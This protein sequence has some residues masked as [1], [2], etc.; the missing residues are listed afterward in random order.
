MDKTITI[1][2]RFRGAVAPPLVA[3]RIGEFC[4]LL[5]K[6]AGSPTVAAVSGGSMDLTLDNTNEVQSACLYQ[7]N[8]LPFD[9]D[10]LVR[11]EIL[12]QL[13]A[14]LGNT[15]S[16]T[17]GVCDTQN[18]DP[19]AIATSA[20]FRC[21]LSNTV[22]CETDDGTNETAATSTGDTLAATKKRFAIDFTEP[23]TQSPPSASLPGKGNVRFAMSNSANSLRKVCSNTRFNM[24]SATGNLQLLAQLQKTQSVQTAT[25]KIFEFLVTLKQNV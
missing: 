20:F 7:G 16:A 5:V 3:S 10:D 17:F 9:I 1:P 6:T 14:S 2:Y 12:A 21:K 23:F 24:N 8:I 22:T 15:I 4:S 19:D 13:T 11:V 18:A 25:L